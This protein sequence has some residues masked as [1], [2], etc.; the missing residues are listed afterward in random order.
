MSK[1]SE[2][3]RTAVRR[4]EART[5]R[6]VRQQSKKKRRKIV[7]FVGSGIFA[8][9][10]IVGLFL[11]SL[12][13][14]NLGTG[15]GAASYVDGVGIPQPAM[16]TAYHVDGKNVSYSTLPPTSGDHWSTPAQCGFYDS[17]NI[18]DEVIVHNMEH[19]NVVISYNIS[20]ES[21]KSRLKELHSRLTGSTEWLVTR[22]YKEIPEGSIALTAWGIADEFEGVSEERITRFVEAYSGNLFSDETKRLNR[23]IPCNNVGSMTK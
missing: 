21:Q 8:V 18:A 10:I 3:R 13:I 9:A 4:S 22:P 15:G 1:D 6:R 5:E 14:G 19:G 17:K 23:G 16:P 12:P 2:K 20:D 11:P 7:Y